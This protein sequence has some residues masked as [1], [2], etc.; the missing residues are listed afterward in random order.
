MYKLNYIKLWILMVVYFIFLISS[1]IWLLL[2]LLGPYLS[3]L[4]GDFESVKNVYYLLFSFICHQKAERSYF[5]WGYQMPVCV[6]C[7]GIYLGV[8]LGTLIYP[9]FKKINSTDVPEFKYYWILFTPLLVD[10]VAQLLH[11]YPSPHY[12][13]L[14]TGILAAGGLVFYALPVANQIYNHLINKED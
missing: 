14:A 2:L 7:T 12:V 10:G 1:F 11:L 6:R 8:F 13:R 3:G 5:I 9:I 4:G